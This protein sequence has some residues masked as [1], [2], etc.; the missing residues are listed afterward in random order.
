MRTRP[1]GAS[2]KPAPIVLVLGSTTSFFSDL[3]AFTP[4]GCS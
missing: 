2:L 3:R 1:Q 4:W